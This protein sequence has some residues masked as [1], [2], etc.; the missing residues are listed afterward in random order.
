MFDLIQSPCEVAMRQMT[1]NSIGFQA[2]HKQ[3]RRER[4]LSEIEAVIPWRD[5]RSLIEHHYPSGQRGRP[6]I[7]IERM[8]ERFTF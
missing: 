7:G 1:L 2:H 6:P 5:L 3:T 8:L 4:F